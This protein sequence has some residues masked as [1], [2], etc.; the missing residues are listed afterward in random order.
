[1]RRLA[2]LLALL[3]LLAACG[4]T[5]PDPTPYP[6]TAPSAPFD[7]ARQ[8][9]NRFAEAWTDGEHAAMHGMLAPADRVAWDEAAFAAAYAVVDSGRG[10][11]CWI[12]VT[13]TI[14][15]DRCA[16]MD[17]SSARSSRTAGIRLRSISFLQ[18]SSVRTANPPAGACEPPRTLTM[19]S[20]PPRCRSASCATAVQPSAVVMFA[21]T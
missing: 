3:T 13:W 5:A 6:T 20:M 7:E 18:S 19:M 1:M 11:S 8:V 14:T 12:D 4:P 9:V 21:A 16:S 17:G 15:P 2:S 10:S